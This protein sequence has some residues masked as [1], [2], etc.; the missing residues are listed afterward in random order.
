[1]EQENGLSRTESRGTNLDLRNRL[2]RSR[3]ETHRADRDGRGS[4]LSDVT[5]HTCLSGSAD[6]FKSQLHRDT[7]VLVTVN[8]TLLKVFNFSFR[9]VLVIYHS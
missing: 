5:G 8:L 6:V 9:V 3:V 1:M 7:R 2:K 4:H